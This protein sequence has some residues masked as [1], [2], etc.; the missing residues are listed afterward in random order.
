MARAVPLPPAFLGAPIA[1]RGLHDR[2]GG[3]IENSRA[4][5]EAA[6]AAGYGIECDIQAS[7]DGE[8]FVFHDDVLERLTGRN[9]AFNA[10]PAAE[11]AAIPLAG[12]AD[13]ET[14]PT[15]RDFLALVA[16]RVPLLIEVKDQSH[17]LGPGVGALERRIAALLAGYGGPVAL[18]SFNPHS[19]AALAEAAPDL[20]RGLTSCAFDETEWGIAAARRA[21][22]ARLADFAPLGCGFVSHDR[23]DLGNP[24]VGALRAGGT[25]ILTWTIRSPAEEAA[26]RR[27]AHNITF[28]GYRP[29]A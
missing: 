16:G 20:P 9:G 22:L 29:A 6:I 12:A 27:V 24:A 26:A 11:L 5:A 28:E 2:A 17:V 14:I 25:P 8:A 13:H 19:V 18:M 10:R 15:L 4:A 21:H 1:H 23:T 7:A 3:R